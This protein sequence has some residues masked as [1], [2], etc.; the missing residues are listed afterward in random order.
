MGAAETMPTVDRRPWGLGHVFLGLL[1]A[2]AAVLVTIFAF[3]SGGLEG[4]LD[5]L[6]LE[7][8]AV[9]QAALW[10]GTLGVPV[11]LVWVRGVSWS[12]LGW[13]FRRRDTVSGLL[14][15]IGTQVV[16][17]PLL[18][19]PLMLLVDDLDIAEP[20]RDLVDKATGA[21]VAIL[22]LV[23]VVG[24]PIVEEVFYRGLTLRA[25]EGRMRPT[26]ALVVSSLLFAVIHF[27]VTQFPALLLFG[28]VAGR[29][30]QKDGRLGRAIWAHIG[31]NGTTILLLLLPVSTI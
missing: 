21:G 28:L 22:V 8:I 14:I 26:F 6:S 11:W 19:L 1:F 15:G 12:E 23:V 5:D 29:L 9:L 24:A 16:A 20:A 18:Y 3:G 25:L 13:G 10:L 31:F 7:M 27:Q 17:V 2:E 4:E 30:A